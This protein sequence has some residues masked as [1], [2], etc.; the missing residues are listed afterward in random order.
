MPSRLLPPWLETEIAVTPAS[1]ARS[2]VVD[3]HDALEHE[4]PVPLLAQPG[5]VVPRRRRRLHPL[6]VGAEERRR[7]SPPGGAMFGHGQVRAAA[8]CVANVAQ[9]ARRSSDLGRELEHRLE[10][11]L[12][13]DRRAAPV[14]AVRERPVER[15]D[16]PDGAGRRGRARC[17]AA[18]R[19]ACR[20]STA[21]RTSAG[22]PR[23]PPRSACSRTS[24]GPSP[25]R[26]PRPRGRPRPRRRGAR[27]ARRSARSSPAARSPGP[28]RSSPGRAA[29]RPGGDR[30]AKPELGEGGDVVVDA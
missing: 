24:S 23:R 6:A 22:W 13:G 19:R 10:V 16:Q 15:D 28:S 1:T 14:A 7:G 5:D 20:T 18:S 3:P 4:R 21:G 25:C 26:A 9:P 29:R 2:R 11:E 30:G 12:L 17:A 8:R 27:P